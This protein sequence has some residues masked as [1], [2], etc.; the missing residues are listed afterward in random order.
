M[1]AIDELAAAFS[2]QLKPA[3]SLERWL[4]FELARSSVQ[5]DEASDQLLINRMRII[6]RIGTSW[7]DDNDAFSDRLGARLSADPYN[8]QR[9]LA[10]SKH[11]A[12][13]L[14]H[15]WTL[16]DEVGRDERRARRFAN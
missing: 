4:V 5:C 8:V 2:I 1:D 6:E 12:L 13:Y 15:K 16:L 10:R 11:G 14:I 9:E 7:D 3:T